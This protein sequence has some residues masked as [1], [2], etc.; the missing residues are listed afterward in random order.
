VRLL[1]LRTHYR[2]PLEF[3]KD[4]LDDAAASLA[5]LWA[6]RRRVDGPVEDSPDGEAMGRF[7]AAMDG[8][9][10]VAGGLA[11]LFEVVREGNRRLD[12]GEAAAA[13][14][15][16]YDEITSMLAIDEVPETMTGTEDEAVGVAERFGAADLDALLERR[17]AARAEGDFEL[18]DQIR[19]RLAEIGIVVEDTADGS[20]W[21]RG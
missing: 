5:R 19:D 7:Q 2:K 18:S 14:V 17:D 16:A 20:R 9:F 4:A 13:L 15:A 10:D 8:D 3:S 6:F 11:V 12:E 1:Y 21:H